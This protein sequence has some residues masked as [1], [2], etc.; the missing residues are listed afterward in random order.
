MVHVV[1]GYYLLIEF[2]EMDFVRA[3][4]ILML[5]V[6]LI[7]GSIQHPDTGLLEVVCHR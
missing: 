7:L 3:D 1:E 2:E 4:G 6:L 5:K